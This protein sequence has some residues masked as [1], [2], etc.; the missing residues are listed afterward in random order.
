MKWQEIYE[1]MTG[2]IF[3]KLLNALPWQN[4]EGV[5]LGHFP[6]SV[7]WKFPSTLSNLRTS[8]WKSPGHPSRWL[9]LPDSCRWGVCECVLGWGWGGDTLPSSGKDSICVTACETVSPNAQC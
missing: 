1:M 8:A 4:K 6:R 7:V 9:L 2:S 3:L 5:T